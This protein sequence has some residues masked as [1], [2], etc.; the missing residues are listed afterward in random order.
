[1]PPAGDPDAAS[2]EAKDSWL[3][4]VGV[5]GTRSRSCDSGHWLAGGSIVS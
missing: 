3:S 4:P 1:M 2:S 5:G